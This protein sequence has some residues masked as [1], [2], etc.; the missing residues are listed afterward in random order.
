MPDVHLSPGVATR[1]AE[2]A[3]LDETNA[4]HFCGES[5]QRQPPLA[6]A[7][8]RPPRLLCS[9]AWSLELPGHLNSAWESLQIC[10]PLF[11]DT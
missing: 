4:V 1:Q 11:R 10:A 8:L 2:R 5:W 9:T 6:T 3:D 7:T